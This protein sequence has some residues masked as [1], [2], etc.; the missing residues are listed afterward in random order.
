MEAK[1]TPSP[2]LS[3]LQ[4]YSWQL[5]FLVALFLA[6]CLPF[7]L[8]RRRLRFI[9]N[10]QNLW[11]D[12]EQTIAELTPEACHYYPNPSRHILL[13][14]LSNHKGVAR[15][16]AVGPALDYLA[17]E[18]DSPIGIVRSLSYLAVLVGLLG[19][20]TLLALALQSVDAIGQ[21]KIE[22]LKNIYPLNAV[23]IG[24]AVVMYLSFSWYRHQGDQFLLQVSRILGRLRVDQLG[25]S[26]PALLATLEKVGEKFK[27][28]GDEIH[29]QHRQE[30]NHLLQE[31]RDL[32][33]SIR[34]VVVAAIAARQEEDRVIMP[35]LLSQDAKL[36]T[37]NQ[38]LYQNY[39]LL[40]QGTG[41]QADLPLID[42]N[43]G[44]QGRSG[45]KT[46]QSRNRKKT[47]FF[48]RYFK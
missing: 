28:W 30:I 39:L 13:S 21:F 2:I 34:Q 29:A 17:A 3:W 38:R 42:Q 23:A 15:A 24:L 41:S 25:A 44:D 5:V 10:Q 20:V 7:F 45:N 8:L 37:L 19:T 35:L 36:E 4:T 47:G 27:D 48:S 31:V 12:L 14:V 43:L 16:S 32:G 6:V 9:L 40:A 18:V 22:Q 46:S 33:E 1:L 11:Q 26:D